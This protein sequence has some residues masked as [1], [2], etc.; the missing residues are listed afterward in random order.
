MKIVKTPTRETGLSDRLDFCIPEDFETKRGPPKK[1][2]KTII[3][4]RPKKV[5]EI[6]VYIFSGK[7]PSH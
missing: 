4:F 2:R 6:S 1:V 5:G 3:L 7:C